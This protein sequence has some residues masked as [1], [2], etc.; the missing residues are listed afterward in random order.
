MQGAERQAFLD[1]AC[2]ADPQLRGEVDDLL[3]HA[4]ADEVARAHSDHDFLLSP[5]IRDEPS[6][7][8]KAIPKQI[9]S[10]RILS[11]LG[12]GAMGTV[13]EAEQSQPRREVALKVLR[14]SGLHT[15]KIHRFLKEVYILGQ[16]RHAGIAQIYEAGVDDEQQPYFAMELVRGLPLDKYASASLL[17][18]TQRLQ[19]IIQ[20]LEAVEHAHR[21]GVIHRDLKPGNI[22]VDAQGCPKVLDFGVARITGQEAAWMTS[23][24]ETGQWLGTL[25]YMSPE[26]ISSK[27]SD[28]DGRS[29]VYA[30]GLLL[31]EVLSNRRAY[32]LSDVPL[33]EVARIIREVEPPLLG[34][35]DGRFS[36]DIETIV[37][38]A[39]EKDRN[40]RY[41]SPAEMR[42]DIERYLRHETIVARPPSSLYRLRK[43]SRRN[44]QLLT[45]IATLVVGL[46]GTGCFAA[47]AWQSA[48]L[49][50]RDR[51]A[52]LSE[53]YTA[54]LYA[55]G[56]ALDD[57]NVSAAQA[58]LSAAP[59]SMRG[60]EWFHLASRMG[61]HL[62]KVEGAAGSKIQRGVRGRSAARLSS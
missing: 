3:K 48:Q 21:R 52:A 30:L 26:Q 28:I 27:P 18:V 49:A 8:A 2:G 1:T 16:L 17:T 61:N 54:R 15:H 44:W 12:S 60:W 36:G 43:F 58:Q 46:V 31:F 53:A 22:L 11:L 14:T 25:A 6:R 13:Y 57:Y 19:L 39:I 32:E 41:A 47:L 55:A 50:K 59:E 33:P 51:E 38:K 29:D 5:V 23:V 10:Y 35:I 20:I 9:G 7:E 42:D 45:I 37:A 34:T 62:S 56:N 40:R 24:T 4:D